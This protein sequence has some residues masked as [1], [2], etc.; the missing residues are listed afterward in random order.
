MP[1]KPKGSRHVTLR[2][3]PQASQWRCKKAME[4]Q[5]TPS[6]APCIPWSHTRVHKGLGFRVQGLGVGVQGLG[7][8][9][10]I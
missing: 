2:P 6:K 9:F 1:P 5:K 7:L 8:G 3:D 4:R 10:R